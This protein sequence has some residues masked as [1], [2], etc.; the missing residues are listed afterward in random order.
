MNQQEK[1]QTSIMLG[2]KTEIP[3]DVITE[4]PPD[5]LDPHIKDSLW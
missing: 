4:R 2:Q 3:R 1:R 5:S